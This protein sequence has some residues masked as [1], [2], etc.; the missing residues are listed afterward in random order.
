MAPLDVN[1]YNALDLRRATRSDLAVCIPRVVVVV[2]VVVVGYGFVRV[3][4][5]GR[6]W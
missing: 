1:A 2:V 3:W 5:G 4:V 6:E